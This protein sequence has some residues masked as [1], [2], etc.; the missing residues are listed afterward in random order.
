[1]LARLLPRLGVLV[2]GLALVVT[3]PVWLKVV[4]A[5]LVAA[6]V[7]RDPAGWWH[8][9]RTGEERERVRRPPAEYAEPGRHVVVLG[10]AGPRRIETL[11]AI[12]EVTHVGLAQAKDWVDAAPCAIAGWL[13][14]DSADRIRAR[15][16]EAGA[17]AWVEE[18]S[19]P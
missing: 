5:L 12:R 18:G 14:R 17:T 9:V 15:L 7:P 13:S 10:H 1:M 3:G 6:A 11:K 19:V 8:L 2:V 16:E 4:G